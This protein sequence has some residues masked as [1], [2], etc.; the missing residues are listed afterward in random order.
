MCSS[1]ARKDL[2]NLAISLSFAIRASS[3]AAWPGGASR[4]LRAEQR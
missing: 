2:F 3:L 1:I 4:F